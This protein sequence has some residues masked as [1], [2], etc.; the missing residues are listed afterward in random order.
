[1]GSRNLTAFITLRINF[2]C[3]TILPR[4]GQYLTPRR[5]NHGLIS[6]ILTMLATSDFTTLFL[7]TYAF[8]FYTLVCQLA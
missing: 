8:Y 4:H 1:M 7:I 3:S 6:L 2:Y 5:Q